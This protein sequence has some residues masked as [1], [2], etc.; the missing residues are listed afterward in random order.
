MWLTTVVVLVGLLASTSGKA[1]FAINV[2]VPVHN[3]LH[4]SSSKAPRM[5]RAT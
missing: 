4:V 2:Q 3:L 1:K 5:W